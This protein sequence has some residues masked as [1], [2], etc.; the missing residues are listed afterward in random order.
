[1]QSTQRVAVEQLLKTMD[2]ELYNGEL[3]AA[4]C[5][6]IKNASEKHLVGATL[7][8]CDGFK[9]IL[10]AVGAHAG[11]DEVQVAACSAINAMWAGRYGHEIT[12]LRLEG[13][14]RLLTLMAAHSANPILLT[15]ACDA[16]Q[17]VAKCED[18]AYNLVA[19]GAAESLLAA[20]AGHPGCERLQEAANGAMHVL[21]S[22]S[23]G[24]MVVK[25][26]GIERLLNAMG[27]LITSR[28]AQE[29]A[30]GAMA[31]LAGDAKV[32]EE[33]GKSNAGQ[34]VIEAMCEHPSSLEL[35][36]S[37]ADALCNL[38]RIPYAKVMVQAGAV[39]CL[40]E[41]ASRFPS[42]DELQSAVRG[43]LLSLFEGL[44][45]DVRELT[46]ITERF[47]SSEKVQWAACKAMQNMSATKVVKKGVR[48]DGIDS[49]Y[50]A[51]N[52]QPKEG[53][54]MATTTD[55]GMTKGNK[56]AMVKAGVVEALLDASALHPE[57]KDIQD[58]AGE[59]LLALTHTKETSV[60]FAQHGGIDQL[61]DSMKDNNTKTVVQERAT[62]TLC[63]LASVGELGFQL[64]SSG[65]IETLLSTMESHT[66]S[67]AVQAHSC[68]A[69]IA[70]LSPTST[71]KQDGMASMI[72]ERAEL[73]AKENGIQRIVASLLA[74]PRDTDLRAWIAQLLL[75]LVTCSPDL[76][77]PQI[78]EH[79]GKALDENVKSPHAQASI[80]T[81]LAAL[82]SKGIEVLGP[83]V[84]IDSLFRVLTTHPV[85]KDICK[86]IGLSFYAYTIN[87]EKR[88][89]VA[90]KLKDLCKSD[91]NEDL[92]RAAYSILGQLAV[93]KENAIIITSNGGLEQI[94]QAVADCPSSD[95]I[96]YHDEPFDDM[97]KIL[98]ELLL[99]ISRHYDREKVIK[100]LL[101]N[102]KTSP[103]A[104]RVLLCLVRD[105]DSAAA[106]VDQ[107]GIEKL[108]EVLNTH[109][110]S[111]EVNRDVC[112]TLGWLASNAQIA[113][114][115]RSAGAMQA[116]VQSMTAFGQDE[117]VQ[118]SASAALYRY[119]AADS[120]DEIHLAE[121]I[122]Q[123]GGVDKLVRALTNFPDS[124]R[125]LEMAALALERLARNNKT[126]AARIEKARQ[127][128]LQ[129]PREQGGYKTCGTEDKSTESKSPPPPLNIIKA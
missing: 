47:A 81:V 119:A 111:A 1:M 26:R 8:K 30:V 67:A 50:D 38:A 15:M 74:H 43:A 79:L 120:A 7:I 31:D 102:G 82:E 63:R 36:L 61:L 62:S 84:S 129:S 29:A 94:L 118:V 37:A 70:M 17:R 57:S 65:T 78:I 121:Y 93:D 123:C 19:A 41:A 114:L 24:P 73:I 2:R 40:Q 60:S 108:L 66:A 14:E 12:G 91:A 76:F 3:Q 99:C 55:T 6:A 52:A 25:V 9:R 18:T 122:A 87:D 107:G 103:A 33:L 89:D 68:E 80:C 21:F 20:I 64:H 126:V 42:N 39:D 23:S 34:R 128:G 59:V 86:A 96:N 109:K 92:A 117:Q 90:G 16:V 28:R 125:V 5:T 115:M 10:A 83:V 4:A 11:Y 44:G 13:S 22:T 104:A 124:S 49:Y 45:P 85:N 71:T 32:A 72:T 100:W 27:A 58:C 53:G 69:L 77:V 98:S 48:K 95:S 88:L 46:A 54:P 112:A 116:V 97:I 35:H 75:E 51:S 105:R 101:D 56:E 113:S 110:K 106:V 127:S